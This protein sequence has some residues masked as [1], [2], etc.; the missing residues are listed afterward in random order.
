MWKPC[1]REELVLEAAT[2]GYY[3]P[4]M[5]QYAVDYVKRCDA[6]Q[7]HAPAIHQP[8]ELLHP[9]LPSWPFMKWGTDIVGKLPPAPGQKVFI[10]A[11]TDYFSNDKTEAFCKKG[12]IRLVKSTPRYPQA[13]GQAESSNMVLWSDKTTPKVSIGHT[14]YSLVYGTEAVLPTEIMMPTARYGLATTDTNDQELSHDLDIIDK[15]REMEKVRMASY[16]QRV[17]NS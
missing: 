7:R 14:P 9:S 10:L 1:Q 12:N 6:C 11:I 5:S 17:A 13:N 16:Q 15:A 4:I 2:L 3:W 8:S